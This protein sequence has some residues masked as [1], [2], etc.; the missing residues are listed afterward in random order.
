[1]QITKQII[2]I[3]YFNC[4]INLNIEKTVLELQNIYYREKINNQAIYRER[5]I[6][7]DFKIV[8]D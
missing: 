8:L 6:I 4:T 2:I 7:L 3:K 1:M 5:K